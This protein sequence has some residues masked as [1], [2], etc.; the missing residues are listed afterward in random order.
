MSSFPLCKMKK[1][2]VTC[3]VRLNPLLK[4]GL[5]VSNRRTHF[6]VFLGKGG[7]FIL[8]LKTDRRFVSTLFRM[9][10]HTFAHNL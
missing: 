3:A 2:K 10:A 8:F 6:L 9:R 1:K 4:T 5:I 7:G